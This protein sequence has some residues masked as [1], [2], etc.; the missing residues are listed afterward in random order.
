MKIFAV[1][2]I[3]AGLSALFFIYREKIEGWFPGYKTIIWNGLV[4]IAGLFGAIFAF[5]K[6]NSGTFGQFLTPE[7]AA[8]AAVVVGVVGILISYVTKRASD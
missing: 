6:D 7:N 5:L 4:S 3:L 2:L 8:L 1:L